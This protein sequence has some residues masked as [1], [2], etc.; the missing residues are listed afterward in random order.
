MLNFDDEET[1]T[2]LLQI[3]LALQLTV[4]LAA[5]T[6]SRLAQARYFLKSPITARH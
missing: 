6:A 1:V 4:L 5:Q 2:D 3:T